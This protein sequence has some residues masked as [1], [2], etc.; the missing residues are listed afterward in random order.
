MLTSRSFQVSRVPSAF[1][2]FRIE[3]KTDGRMTLLTAGED[4]R[5]VEL[6]VDHLIAWGVAPSAAA[7]AVA[8]AFS[9]EA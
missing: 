6:A 4:A 9:G 8:Q 3:I 2:G 1:G 5:A 7:V